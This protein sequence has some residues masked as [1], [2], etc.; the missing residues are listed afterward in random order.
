M[1]MLVSC[2]ALPEVKHW[3]HRT[4]PTYF[5]GCDCSDTALELSVDVTAC[6]AALAPYL[7][8]RKA[9]LSLTRRRVCS[10]ASSLR[11]RN[12][13]THHGQPDKLRSV[14]ARASWLPCN[15]STVLMAALLM[16][17]SAGFRC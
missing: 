7:C 10:S 1:L 13:V 5:L 3:Q 9:A 2:V 14:A 15:P 17:S 6:P 12:S 8:S 16:C 4:W 11:C